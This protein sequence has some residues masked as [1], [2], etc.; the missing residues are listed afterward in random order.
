MK[1]SIGNDH[2][3]TDYKKEI[4]KHLKE[5]KVNVVNNGTDKNDSVDY[6]DHIHPVAKQVAKKRNQVW[7]NCL[8]KWK[9]RKHDSKQTPKNKKCT[10]LE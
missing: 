4:I 2:A 1:I 8:W 5:K 9:W 10:L 7:D 3:G 6:P